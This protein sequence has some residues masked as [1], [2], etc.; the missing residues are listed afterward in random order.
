MAKSIQIECGASGALPSKA[1]ALLSQRITERTGV[2][3]KS[4]ANGECRI[5]LGVE[6]GIG[7]QGYRIEHEA[8]GRVRIAGNDG[9]GLIYGVGKFLRSSRFDE[10]N[11]TP[12][13]WRGTSVPDMEVRGMYFATHFHNFYHDAPIEKVIRYVEDLALW[14]CN[15]LTVWF[16]MHHYTGIDDPDAQAMIERLRSIL[17]AAKRVGMG[18][19]LGFLANEAYSTSPEEL[20]ADWTAGHDGYTTP[21]RGH[22]R[23][24]I[25]PNKPGGLELILRWRRE[26]LEAFRGA[27]P[28]YIWI[29]PY[30][31]GGCTCSACAPW[32][33][34]G[35]LKTAEPVARL[36]REMCPSAKIVLST[37]YFD[38]FTSGE[39]EGL[40]AAFN[41]M[42]PDWVDYL[43][44]DS[45]GAFPEY[46]LKYGIPGG[47][48]VVGFPEISM[49]GMS[50]WGGFG[51]NPRPHHWQ[52][53]WNGVRNVLSGG[54][55][56]SEGI[57]EDINKA[58][59]LQF[60][61][62]SRSE[63]LEIVREYAAYEYSPDV[64]DDVVRSVAMLEE[65]EQ[66]GL[67]K[68]LKEKLSQ[69]S[70]EPIHDAAKHVLYE[71]PK[72]REPERYL[73]LLS[74]AEE[75]LA[76]WAKGSWRWRVLWLR[77]TLDCE[78]HRSGGRPTEKSEAFFEELMEIYFAENTKDSVAPPGIRALRRRWRGRA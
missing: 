4:G 7:K 49:E 62:N 30:D 22:Y 39:W 1:C 54:F 70:C 50:P 15:A 53:Y 10:G 3:V 25:C 51:A 19:S 75:K 5:V 35:Y 21:P 67:N 72:V 74:V 64:A 32:G 61:W 18:A 68:D 31:Q 29:W 13:A 65:C 76:K 58:V 37:W 59:M 44:A 40:S 24:E 2:D 23:V 52:E 46:P 27:D 12:G 45:F 78:L 41:R 11:F 34:N 38:K 73:D 57:Y 69:F 36:I 8:H 43:L 66:H 9:R 71:L 16:D 17:D 20:R 56:Y 77:A 42:K 48:P 55:P 47:I 33:I 60:Y 63:A 14:G 26:M 28:E 6:S